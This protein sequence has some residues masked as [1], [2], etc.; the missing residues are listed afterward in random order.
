MKASDIVRFRLHNQQI[1]SCKCKSAAEVVFQLGAVQAQDYAG[2]KWSIGL[3][4]PGTTD[5][6]IEQAIAKKAIVRTWSMRG[7]LHFVAA[8]DVRW[9][10]GLLTPRILAGHRGRQQQMGLDDAIFRRCEKIFTRAL[11]GGGQLGRTEMMTLLKREKISTDGLRGYHILWRIAQEGTICFGHRKEKEHTFVLLDEWLPP[12]K[13]L[14]REEALTEL[15]KRYFASHGPAM[16]RDFVWWSGLKVADVTA[17][18]QGAGKHLRNELV[19]G[20]EYWMAAKVSRE[21]AKKPLDPLAVYLLPGFDEYLLGYNDRSLVLAPE[22]SSKVC[23]G[24]NGVFSPTVVIGGRVCG[25]WKRTIKKQSVVIEPAFFNK[26]N[27]AESIAFR[28]AREHYGRFIGA[29]VSN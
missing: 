9:M 8:Q 4:F 25:T 29:A 17:G 10:L 19:D 23:T 13:M 16:V 7:T 27:K 11:Q 21:V 24:S 5:V 3:R 15:A 14:E 26:V 12:G 20:R 2:A 22:H 1:A 18:I 6:D 28:A